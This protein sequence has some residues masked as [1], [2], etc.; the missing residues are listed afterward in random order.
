M[1]HRSTSFGGQGR[2]VKTKSFPCDAGR[3]GEGVD[4]LVYVAMFPLRGHIYS[5]SFL[6][7]VYQR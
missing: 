3:T 5:L 4:K 1:L 2:M 6:P 7:G